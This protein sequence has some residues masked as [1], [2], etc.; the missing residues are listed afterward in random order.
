[1]QGLRRTK[2]ALQAAGCAETSQNPKNKLVQGT[3]AH[4]STHHPQLFSAFGLLNWNPP[5]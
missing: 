3:P 2:R 5:T 4:P 1:M